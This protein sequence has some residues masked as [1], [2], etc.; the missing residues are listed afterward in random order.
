MHNNQKTKINKSTIDIM[1]KQTYNNFIE[2]EIK[3]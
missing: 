3:T 1:M 2:K